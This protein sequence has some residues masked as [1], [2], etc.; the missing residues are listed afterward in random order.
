M[1]ESWK[2][3]KL[4]VFNRCTSQLLCIYSL[5]RNFSEFL[6]EKNPWHLRTFIF[7]RLDY[8][9]QTSCPLPHKSYDVA[10]AKLRKNFE[11]N[12]ACELE[13]LKIT[14]NLFTVNRRHARRPNDAG[15]QF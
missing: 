11:N 14:F 12:V 7:I 4:A 5:T 10:T 6:Q 13:V 9:H 3:D 2:L 8:S 15:M 1:N